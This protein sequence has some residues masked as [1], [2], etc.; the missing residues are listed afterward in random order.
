PTGL[1]WIVWVIQSVW[2]HMKKCRSITFNTIFIFRINFAQVAMVLNVGCIFIPIFLARAIL[3]FPGTFV[4]DKK[5]VI[6]KFLAHPLVRADAE[7][8]FLVPV[9]VGNG[10]N[11]EFMQKLFQVF[12][13]SLL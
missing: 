2:Y 3:K 13:A 5:Q 7:F 12:G 11:A 9:L 6:F 1:S 8:C 10:I 4:P